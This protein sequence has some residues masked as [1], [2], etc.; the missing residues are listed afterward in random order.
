MSKAPMPGARFR[1]TAA[2]ATMHEG[3]RA[4]MIFGGH[5]RCKKAAV[6]ANPDD[7]GGCDEIAVVAAFFEVQ[8]A[9]IFVYEASEDGDIDTEAAQ[10][11]AT[12]V[13]PLPALTGYRMTGAVNAGGGFWGT[14]TQL[15]TARSDFHV[16][17][18]VL[19]FCCCC[20]CPFV[21]LFSSCRKII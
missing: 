21:V 13:S 17:P 7:D 11:I 1:A 15:P 20:V 14:K 6:E 4:V 8:T 18:P 3:M 12:I 19:S 5:H 2:S 16:R 10:M 9:P